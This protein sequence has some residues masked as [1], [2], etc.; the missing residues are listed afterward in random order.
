MTDRAF[1]I[2]AIEER[3][4]AEIDNILS[5]EAELLL[6]RV[7][8]KVRKVADSIALDVLSH[9]SVQQMGNE[10]IIRVVKDG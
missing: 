2:Q 10:V 3:V 1:I 5:V 7:E 6:E 8:A 4:K 9:Y